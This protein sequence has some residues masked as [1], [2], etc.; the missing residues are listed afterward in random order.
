MGARE[1]LCGVTSGK[2]RI[3]YSSVVSNLL[4]HHSGFLFDSHRWDSSWCACTSGIY[5]TSLFW[6]VYHT[7]NFYKNLPVCVP[8]NLLPAVGFTLGNC[9]KS[10]DNCFHTKFVNQDFSRKLVIYILS[11]IAFCS[12]IPWIYILS[13]TSLVYLGM[14]VGVLFFFNY[15]K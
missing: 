3:R 15:S 11:L 12:A 4:K 7:S 6:G 13:V 2:C 14:W 10:A 1:I 8:T 9:V 5:G